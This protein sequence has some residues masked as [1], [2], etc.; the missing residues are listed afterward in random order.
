MALHKKS[1]WR[2][3]NM[4][5]VTAVNVKNPITF[6]AVKMMMVMSGAFLRFVASGAAR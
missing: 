6:L 5:R 1:I 2:L 3:G 4:L